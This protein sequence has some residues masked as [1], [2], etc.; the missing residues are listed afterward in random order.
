MVELDL[1]SIRCRVEVHAGQSY[2]VLELP[3]GIGDDAYAKFLMSSEDAKRLAAYINVS[4]EG[5]SGVSNVV[6]LLLDKTMLEATLGDARARITELESDFRRVLSEQC[7]VDGTRCVS[8]GAH[9]SCVPYL[10]R[11][12]AELEGD[13]RCCTCGGPVETRRQKWAVPTCHACLPPSM[14]P[15]ILHKRRPA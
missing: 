12:I 8:S 11:R 1:G 13:L 15:P 4:I 2:L 5:D 7:S 14:P 10:R 9:C 6:R 3:W